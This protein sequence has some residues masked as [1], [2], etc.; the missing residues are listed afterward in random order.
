MWQRYRDRVLK[1]VAIPDA[2]RQ[3]GDSEEFPDREAANRNDQLRANELELPHPP[4]RA[5]LPL[6][7][8]GRTVATPGGCTSGIA[9]G[10]RGAIEPAVELVLVHLQPAA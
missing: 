5:K 3:S 1:L 7:R 10:D 9:A 4:E 6:T 2:F 8:C